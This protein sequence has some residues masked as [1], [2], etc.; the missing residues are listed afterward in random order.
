MSL[1]LELFQYSYSNNVNICKLFLNSQ[2]D[3][4]LEDNARCSQHKLNIIA[5]KSWALVDIVND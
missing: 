3:N 1:S 2:V 4:G 5:K